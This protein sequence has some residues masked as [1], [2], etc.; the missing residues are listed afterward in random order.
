MYNLRDRC[1][2]FNMLYHSAG[3]PWTKEEHVSFLLGLEKLGKSEWRGIARDFVKTRTPTQ[4][5][6][7]AQKYFLRRNSTTKRRRRSS[8]FDIIP[9]MVSND[10]E[11]VF[12]DEGNCED[13]DVLPEL[14]L[15]Q[16]VPHGKNHIID[17]LQFSPKSHPVC[18]FSDAASLAPLSSAAMIIPETNEI[19]NGTQ[20]D[21]LDV[22][23]RIQITYCDNANLDPMNVDCMG[24]LRDTNCNRGSFCSPSSSFAPTEG[25]YCV[26][27]SACWGQTSNI[28]K[29]MPRT[30]G[31]GDGSKATVHSKDPC[32]NTMR[33]V[34]EPT[35]LSYKLMQEGSRQSAFHVLSQ[36][37]SKEIDGQGNTSNAISVL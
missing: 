17:T 37:H 4:V 35:P 26:P 5:A 21:N 27:Y 13:T 29:P 3:I 19:S 15:G 7:H 18:R 31:S 23:Q 8:L 28:V 10:G 36:Q 9:K 14:T 11:I 20:C 34:M 12:E 6:S 30:L 25:F 2:S 24:P 1:F 32:I 16:S 33:H 22:N